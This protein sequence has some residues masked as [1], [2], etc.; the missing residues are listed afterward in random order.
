MSHIS[1]VS[2]FIKDSDKKLFRS[3]PIN[4][5]NIYKTEKIQNKT[6]LIMRSLASQRTGS[7]LVNM[8]IVGSLYGGTTDCKNRI[9]GILFCFVSGFV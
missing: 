4:Q 8:V 3:F 1:S 5:G 7:I 6:V 2:S 9:H